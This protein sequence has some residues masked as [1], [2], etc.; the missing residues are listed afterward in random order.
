ME[1]EELRRTQGELEAAL[2]DRLE[3]KRVYMG[4][5]LRYGERREVLPAVLR[6]SSLEYELTS[7]IRKLSRDEDGLVAI[8]PGPG[9][10]NVR[11]SFGPLVDAHAESVLDSLRDEASSLT[12]TLWSLA[13]P[14]TPSGQLWNGLGTTQFQDA[15]EEVVLVR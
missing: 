12:Q 11:L 1:N 14:R 5:V 10:S 3:V 9:D 4:I 15:W 6:T 7:R 13:K 8:V 2:R